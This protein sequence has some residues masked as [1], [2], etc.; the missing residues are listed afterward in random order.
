MCNFYM[1]FYWDATIPDPFP[2]GAACP[3]QESADIVSSEYPAE[4]VSLLPLH[5]EWEHEAHQSGKPFGNFC[6]YSLF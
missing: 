5:P 4:G 1:M 6:F 2:Y 3:I